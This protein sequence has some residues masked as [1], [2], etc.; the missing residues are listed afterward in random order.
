MLLKSTK[1]IYFFPFLA[2]EENLHVWSP[3]GGV[4]DL[5]GTNMSRF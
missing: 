1:D 3:K 5:K 4:V 2:P